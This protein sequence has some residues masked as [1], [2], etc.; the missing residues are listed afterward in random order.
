[1]RVLALMLLFS[2]PRSMQLDYSHKVAWNLPDDVR[3]KLDKAKFF[4]HYELSEEV[5]PFYL[6]GDLDGGGQARL[7][8]IGFGEE[9][10]QQIHCDLSNWLKEDRY[11]DEQKQEH[12]L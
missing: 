5:N 10:K 9:N 1:M 11:P 3:K 4:D 6:R 12:H 8:H 7:C 2:I